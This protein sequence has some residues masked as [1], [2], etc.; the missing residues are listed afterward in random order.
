[1]ISNDRSYNFAWELLRAT[2]KGPLA[3]GRDWAAKFDS[4]Y[5]NHYSV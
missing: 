5:F 2:K 3:E 1:M 4:Y